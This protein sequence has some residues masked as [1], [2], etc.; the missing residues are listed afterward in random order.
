MVIKI[1]VYIN[2][3]PFL[4]KT[5]PNDNIPLPADIQRIMTG[6]PQKM[7]NLVNSCPNSEA[8]RNEN[9]PRRVIISAPN[10]IADIGAV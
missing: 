7:L 8:N 2:N 1:N 9:I 6:I 10:D 4:H 5:K 3:R